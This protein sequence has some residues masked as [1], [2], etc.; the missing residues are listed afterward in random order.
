MVEIL[1]AETEQLDSQVASELALSLEEGTKAKS[2]AARIP[3]ETKSV[4]D[5]LAYGRE[6]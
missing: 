4:S 1:L 5:P 3:P 2:R 6:E